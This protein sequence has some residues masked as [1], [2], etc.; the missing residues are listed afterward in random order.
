MW[1]KNK[2]SYYSNRKP[3][4]GL[5]KSFSEFMSEHTRF[6]HESNTI[7]SQFEKPYLEDDYPRMHLI[8]P[9][10]DWLPGGGTTGCI[11]VRSVEPGDIVLMSINLPGGGGLTAV[12]R[13]GV[14][15]QDCVF[16]GEVNSCQGYNFQGSAK[17]GWFKASFSENFGNNAS[18]VVTGDGNCSGV[19]SCRGNISPNACAGKDHLDFTIQHYSN[20]CPQ[21]V[22]SAPSG[23]TKHATLP[24]EETNC[25]DPPAFTY[26][27]PS[28][29][30]QGSP[31]IVSCSGG[32]S[33]YTWAGSGIT[34]TTSQTLYPTNT[35]QVAEDACGT[36]TVSITDACY[37]EVTGYIRIT[38]AGT[39]DCSVTCTRPS[40]LTAYYKDCYVGAQK[41]RT[42]YW[43][44]NN[45]GSC[46]SGCNPASVNISYW[47]PSKGGYCYTVPDP[48]CDPWCDLIPSRL[49]TCDW[50]C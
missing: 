29:A 37:K 28:E 50:I 39:W 24:C 26:S 4:Y 10:P 16:C 25:K 20:F 9:W 15:A 19:N 23:C 33:P 47:S 14:F 7:E 21:Q 42:Y 1:Y 6:I 45:D 41:Q 40:G 8:D 38:D 44:P 17:A 22:G 49:E 18:T 30:T 43:C 3:Y 34:F 13:Q 48:Q 27:S 46:E 32:V 31:I 2:Q 35:G 36:L 5:N 11:W 12:R